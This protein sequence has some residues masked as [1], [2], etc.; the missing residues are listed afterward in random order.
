MI[1]NNF[2]FNFSASHIGGGFKRLYNY[3]AWFNKNG[4][5]RFIIHPN[6]SSLIDT[7]PNNHYVVV[8]PSVLQRLVNDCGY[9]QNIQKEFGIPALYYS[10]GIPI[11]KKFGRVNWFHLSNV[12]PFCTRGIPLSWKQKLKFYYLG[13]RIKSGFKYVDIISAESNF[14]LDQM[15]PGSVVKKVLSVNGLDEHTSHYAPFQQ[16]LVTIIGTQRYKAIKDSYRI[17]EMLRLKENNPEL[18]LVIIGDVKGIPKSLRTDKNVIITGWIKQAEVLEYL[19][20]TKYYISTT[21][22]ENSSNA[23]AEGVFTASE[24]YISDIKPHRE[25]LSGMPCNEISLPDMRTILHVKKENIST[26]NL[27]TWDEV[28]TDMLNITKVYMSHDEQN[29][30]YVI[31][32][33]PVVAQGSTSGPTYAVVRLCEAL[34]A[35]DNKV[36]LATLDWKKANSLNYSFLRH[37]PVGLGPRKLGRSPSLRK[38]IDQQTQTKL[39]DLIHIHGMWQMNAIDP[40][41]VAK[42]GKINLVVSPHG[43]FSKWA[44]EYGSVLKKVFWPLL[45]YPALRNA[46]CFHATSEAEYKDIRR[47][48]FRQPVAIIPHGIDIP[49]LSVKKE[50]KLRT[51]L[52]LARLHRVKGLEILFQAW[53][54]VQ[55]LFPDWQLVIAG[56]DNENSGYINELHGLSQN[57]KLKRVSFIGEQTGIDK[58]NV[59]QTADLYVLPSYT[60]NFALTVAEALAA[61]LPAIVSTGAPWAGLEQHKAGWWIDIS[62]DSLSACLKDALSYSHSDLNEMGIRGRQWM[63]NEFSWQDVGGRMEVTYQWLLDRSKPTP[64]WVRLQ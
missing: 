16:Q 40:C 12:L 19:V 44:M 15:N 21:L 43:S 55:D 38:W 34:I 28:I 39:V 8:R 5:A 3:S 33:I 60:E 48:G 57:L 36:T 10:Y 9:L 46:T 7:F 25:L 29:P 1:Q 50:N 56:S 41:W 53:H 62:I 63:E 30:M 49:D 52:F 47:L 4:G 17:F 6:N 26:V 42:K 32:T 64:N 27:R 11:Y 54:D 23:V 51:L 13:K 22:I 2:L 45:Q 58:L 14:S 37:F 24:S 31:Q 20:K 61:G 35:A 59:Y 18:K